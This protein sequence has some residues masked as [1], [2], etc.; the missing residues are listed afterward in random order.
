VFNFPS[1]FSVATEADSLSAPRYTCPYH[2]DTSPTQKRLHSFFIRLRLFDA[3]IR[4]RLSITDF[5][6]LTSRFPHSIALFRRHLKLREIFILVAD[7][8]ISQIELKLIDDAI[9]NFL[10]ETQLFKDVF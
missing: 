10:I 9:L 5:L 4:F 3:T 8:I 1:D 6:T 7:Y 2:S